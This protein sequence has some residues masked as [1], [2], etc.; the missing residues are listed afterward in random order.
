MEFLDD[1]IPSLGQ[2]IGRF[3]LVEE[4]GRG[5]F[6]IVFRATQVGTGI[7]VA[8][9]I[10]IPQISTPEENAHWLA[11]FE[12]EAVILKRLRHPA[13]I[14]ILDDGFTDK[15]LPFF[16]LEYVH[17]RPLSNVISE[18]PLT[19]VQVVRIADQVLG[20]LEEAHSIG[21]VHR[22]LK[23]DNV[24]ILDVAGADDAVKVLDF[25]IAKLRSEDAVVSTRT[26]LAMGT[27]RYMAPE[28]FEDFKQSDGRV[29]IYSLGLILAECLT[30]LPVVGATSPGAQISAQVGPN[31]HAFPSLLQSL[32]LYDVIAKAT[33]KDRDL[34]FG[35]SREMRE[36]ISNTSLSG[37]VSTRRDTDRTEPVHKPPMAAV[38]SE[39]A[40]TPL[41]QE[42]VAAPVASEVHTAPTA[43]LIR[44]ED[45]GPPEN[46]APHTSQRSLVPAILGVVCLLAVIA[47]GLY[48][49]GVFDQTSSNES[50]VAQSDSQPEEP[51][52]SPA[53]DR[54]VAQAAPEVGD[55]ELRQALVIAMTGVVSAL[56]ETH[57]LHF[58]GTEGALVFLGS[59]QLGALPF[60]GVVPMSENTIELR[61]ELDGHRSETQSLALDSEGAEF[62]L[63]RVRSSRHRDRDRGESEE[64]QEDSN[65]RFDRLRIPITQ[66]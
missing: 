32:P 62:E 65:G 37:V 31:P 48:A 10:M 26:G 56:P 25:G 17:G 60:D 2:T 39:P 28:Q 66:Q 53:P 59:E 36:A 24:M 38:V 8:L 40:V 42:A 30:G 6:G 54:E 29:D 27:P 61:A 7:D 46:G 16:A 44:P 49:T 1:V 20:A 5:G 58:T 50:P 11:R 13:T 57:L 51:D 35:S 22:D 47:V 21:V 41:M 19:S 33:Q 45:S 3:Q 14:R 9:K 12:Q 4:L 43:G 23:P 63:R 34:R 52:A 18:R 55:S 64:T 15:G